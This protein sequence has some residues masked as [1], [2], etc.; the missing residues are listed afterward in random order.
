[1][2]QTLTGLIPIIYRSYDM[3]AREMVGF[4]NHVYR[5][6]EATAAAVGQTIQY[7]VVPAATTGDITPGQQPPDDGDASWG[8]DNM[9]ISKSKYSPIRWTGEEQV[10]VG[11]LRANM[12]SLQI[13]QSIRALVNLVEVDL[14]TAAKEGASRAYGSA[15]N[16][17]FGT[18]GDLSDFAQ[19][20]KILDDNG[21]PQT[22]LHMVMNSA[23]MANLRGKQSVLY[24]V[25]EAG[26]DQ[27]LRRGI[28]GD[29]QGFDLGNSAG[30][31][32]H[33]KGTGTAYQANGALSLGATTLAVDTG[34]NT[35]VAGD[36][37]TI[38][39]GTPADSN[40]YVVKTALSG[41][42]VVIN[43][44]GLL[45]AHIDNDGFTIGNNYT[46]NIA[47]HRMAIHLVTRAPAMPEGGD[48]ADDVLSL[49]DPVSGLTFQ[50]ALYRLYRRVKIEVGIAWGYKVTKPEFVATLLG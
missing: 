18:A 14:A 34:S 25:N 3:V 8:Y 40:K 32:L 20:R 2:A 15:G 9:T 37:L 19:T 4:I 38:A 16:A 7:P 17:P 12:L 36:I 1:M 29:V 27:L 10:S 47:F 26:T 41:G 31:T 11:S 35:I 23:A 44:P 6:S 42:N 28:V 33:T 43:K 46:P 22:D 24:K 50:F 48:A 5:N 21:V 49:T 45:S 13:A 39:N 30:L